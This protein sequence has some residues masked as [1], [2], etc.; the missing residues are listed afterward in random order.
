MQILYEPSLVTPYPAATAHWPTN[1][2]FKS[3]VLGRAMG[4]MLSEKKRLFLTKKTASEIY[5]LKCAKQM[6]IIF[7]TERFNR[8]FLLN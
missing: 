2:L 8:V 4:L 5:N 6:I 3:A 1:K 7:F